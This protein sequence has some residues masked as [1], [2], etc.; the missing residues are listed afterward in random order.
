[1]YCF[2]I[3]IA[4]SPKGTYIRN[5]RLSEAKPGVRQI[6]KFP[7]RH[8]VERGGTARR[9]DMDMMSMCDL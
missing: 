7:L 2:S 4:K 9:I 6:P 8:A 1:M 3:C 5:P